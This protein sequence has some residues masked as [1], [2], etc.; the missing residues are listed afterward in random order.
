MQPTHESGL[1]SYIYV[2]VAAK[3]VGLLHAVM[4]ERYY[5]WR[6]RYQLVSKSLL[7]MIEKKDEF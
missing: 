3:R 4:R 6:D 2:S 5:I 7:T 1:L